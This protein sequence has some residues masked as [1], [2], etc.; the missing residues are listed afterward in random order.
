MAK[1]IA[2]NIYVDNIMIPA[3]N[4]NEIKSLCQ[5]TI[6]MF[7]GAKMN[8]REFNSNSPGLETCVSPDKLFPSTEKSKILGLNWDVKRDMLKIRF[9]SSERQVLT[10]RTMLSFISGVF[11]PLGVV[12]PALLLL[13]L[14][15]AEVCSG[16]NG[17]MWDEPTNE[18]IS[19]NGVIPQK[20]GR[21]SK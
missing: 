10:R 16:Q 17:I 11:D 3:T 1:D 19:E 13:K 8:V 18:I 7:D 14:I 20:I 2:E 12:S 6:K 21:E 4:E 15:L 9:E 5:E